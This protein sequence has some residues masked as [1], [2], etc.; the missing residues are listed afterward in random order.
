MNTGK[1]EQDQL[2]QLVTIKLFGRPY[3]FKA[4]SEVT[5]AQDVADFLVT[6]VDRIGSQYAG[7]SENISDLATMILA[8]L[9]IA[10]SNIEIRKSHNSFLQDI[11]QRS[12][13]LIRKIESSFEQMIE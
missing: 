11:Y 1:V 8:A 13:M 2:E 7:K 4:D 3:T 10:N 5:S 6:E 9:N 12:E